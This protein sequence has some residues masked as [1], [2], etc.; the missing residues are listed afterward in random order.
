M[1]KVTT[2]RI[3]MSAVLTVIMMLCLTGCSK[4][5]KAGEFS[6]K[7]PD[8]FKEI[9]SSL[10]PSA[11]V[12]L[13]S[14]NT[15]LIATNETQQGTLEGF[16]PSSLENY[17]ESTHSLFQMIK[18][19]DAL[20]KRKGY[21]YF[22]IPMDGKDVRVYCMFEHGGDYWLCIFASGSGEYDLKQMLKWADTIKFK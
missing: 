7:M 9:D 13:K 18:E 20:T 19:S 10:F 17:A 2:K 22:N 8:S 15:V 3:L 4:T 14:G 6:I 5:Y 11:D 1:K 21:Y 12:V 16:T